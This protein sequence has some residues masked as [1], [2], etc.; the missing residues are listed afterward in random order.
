MVEQLLKE[1]FLM[2]KKKK[3]YNKLI[4]TTIGITSISVSHGGGV[5]PDQ[6]FVQTDLEPAT[7]DGDPPEIV[8]ISVSENTVAEVEKLFG[9]KPTVDKLVLR[10]KEDDELAALAAEVTP[11]EKSTEDLTYVAHDITPHK[12]IVVKKKGY[13]DQAILYVGGIALGRATQEMVYVIVLPE[14]QGYSY[15]N[16]NFKIVPEVQV[17]APPIN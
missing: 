3:V 2:A 6:V 4:T 10:A 9:V 11:K 7:P 5:I 15:I 8:L 17:Y 12:I 1:L 13:P 14:G 16:K